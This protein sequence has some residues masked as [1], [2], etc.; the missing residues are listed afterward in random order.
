VTVVGKGT[1]EA[2]LAAIDHPR[3]TLRGFVSSRAEMAELYRHHD[4]LLAPGPYETFGLGV[5][6]ALASGMVVVGP[7][8][9]GVGEMIGQLDSAFCFA[10]HDGPGFYAAICRAVASD[11]AAAGNN[12]RALARQYGTWDNAIDR[13]V[14]HYQ[15]L[16]MVEEPAAQRPSLSGPHRQP[17]LEP[18][19]TRS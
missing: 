16:L 3:I 6:E 19:R 14:A 13:M 8:A 2:T 15:S 12:S 10:A 11:L 1:F 5:L 9:G 18:L 4:I 7:R 17:Q